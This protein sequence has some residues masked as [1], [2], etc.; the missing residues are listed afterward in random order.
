MPLGVSLIADK[1]RFREFGAFA[2]WRTRLDF[3]YA[4]PSV[5]D[6]TFREWIVD[7]RMYFPITARNIIA[8]RTWMASSQ[9]ED[10]N[11]FFMGGLNQLRGYD[12][13]QFSGNRVWFMNL[14]YRWPFI[15]EVRAGAMA[16]TD[17]RGLFFLDV[18]GAWFDGF[19]FDFAEDGRLKDAVASFGGGVML[20]FGPLP[21]NIYVS[22]RLPGSELRARLEPLGVS[23][24]P[25]F[26]FYIGP[27]F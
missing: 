2:G 8:W 4:P 5:G 17:I 20:D 25:R 13:L 15:D 9:G 11:V 7:H 23:F 6:L 26:D 19:D 16:I 10:P 1:A 18:G 14:E 12:W 3:R 24:G 21:L 22:Q 27:R